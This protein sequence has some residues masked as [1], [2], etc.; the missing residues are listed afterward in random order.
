MKQIVSHNL[1]CLGASVIQVG[2][3]G[4]D[5]EGKLLKRELKRKGIDISGIFLDKDVP[6]ITKT[7]IIAQHQQIVRID[8]EK[9]KDFKNKELFN[10]IFH[11][12]EKHIDDIDAIIISDYGKGMITPELV[13]TICSLALKKKKII[14][15][16]S[17]VWNAGKN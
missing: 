11:F 3:I 12:I 7:R 17:R 5:F 15:L 6:T 9:N 4:N 16:L 13:N 10:K 8:K 2:K 14:T 1:S